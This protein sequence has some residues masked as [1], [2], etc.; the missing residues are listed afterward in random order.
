VGSNV[1]PDIFEGRVKISGQMTVYFQDAVFRD[2][3]TNETEVS[4]A[5]VMT[6]GSSNTADYIA[7]SFPRVK[8]GG[9]GK[10]DGEKG[11][12]QTMPFTA[13]L[14]SS[15]GSGF[16]VEQTTMQIHDSLAV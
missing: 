5:V 8:M 3:F 6:T 14:A 15:G 16:N 11:L 7:F 4:V 13:L 12:V 9:A 2:Y 1:Y 10:N